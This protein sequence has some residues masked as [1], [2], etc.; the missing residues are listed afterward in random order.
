MRCAL[1]DRVSPVFIQVVSSPLGWS[2]LSSFLVTWFPSGDTQGPS[3]V[4]EAVDVICSGPLKFSYK[5]DDF[6]PLPDRDV[7]PSVHECDV[8]ISFHFDLILISSYGVKLTI[9]ATRTYSNVGEHLIGCDCKGVVKY[10]LVTYCAS[11]TNSL[12]NEVI[13]ITHESRSTIQVQ[14]KQLVH[15]TALSSKQ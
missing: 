3:V 2:P 10:Y 9:T 12:T 13:P 11:F 8:D 4:F 7:G 6:C 14:P 5:Y 1:P 15:Q